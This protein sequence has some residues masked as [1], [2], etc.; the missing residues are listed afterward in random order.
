MTILFVGDLNLDVRI[1]PRD[2]VLMGSDVPGRVSVHGG[3]SAANA[4]V[5][6]S[7]CASGM[8]GVR[9]VCAI[10]DDDNGHILSSEIGRSEVDVHTIVR[11]G[12]RS[13]SVA[14]LIGRDGNRGIVSDRS[15]AITLTS[16]DVRDNWFDG[17]T[18]MHLNGYLLLTRESRPLFHHLV[19]QA[20]VRGIPFSFDPS[21][22]ALLSDTF[23]P[24]DVLRAVAGA[25][26]LFPSRDE[27][28]F[29]TGEE[30]PERAAATLASQFPVVVVTCDV[31][32]AV[33][34]VEG[35]V[36]RVAAMPVAVVDATGAGDAFV[37]GF[38][39]AYVT[40]ASALQSTILA[41]KAAA[42]CVSM[43]GAR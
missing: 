18:W 41:S 27:A 29:L 15:K 43:A 37:G 4:A 16:D 2:R 33:L 23:A 13:R 25:S 22:A 1:E 24:A 9:F 31:E 11:P 10:G 20:D 42:Q 5:W 39:D 26:I 34:A 21:S 17:V 38:L 28:A 35:T 6:A 30:D 32:G 40:G 7:R 12:E 14:V 19:A 8:N 3:G 36:T